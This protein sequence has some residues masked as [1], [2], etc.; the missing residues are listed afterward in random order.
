MQN[1]DSL[2]KRLKDIFVSILLLLVGVNAFYGTWTTMDF[3]FAPGDVTRDGKAFNGAICMVSMK[4]C[5]LSQNVSCCRL[6][7]LTLSPLKDYRYRS[8]GDCLHNAILT[9]LLALQK[10]DCCIAFTRTHS[11]I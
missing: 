5:T 9:C 10:Q 8:R 7:N 6:N 3:I 1:R 2:K 4:H 11:A